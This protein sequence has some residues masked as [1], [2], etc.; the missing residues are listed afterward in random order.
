MCLDDLL[1]QGTSILFDRKEAKRIFFI[2]LLEI[3][4]WYTVNNVWSINDRPAWDPLETQQQR[5]MTYRS[6]HGS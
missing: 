2:P 1:K 6:V 4:Y 5:D 3:F